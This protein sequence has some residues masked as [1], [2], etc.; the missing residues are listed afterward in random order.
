MDDEWAK[1]QAAERR[2]H[3]ELDK[4]SRVAEESAARF[5]GRDD[6]AQ[7]CSSEFL[8]SKL[9][10]WCL[11][12]YAGEL[13]SEAELHAEADAFARRYA[14]R[15]RTRRK[16]EP[17]LS[18]IPAAEVMR[19]PEPGPEEVV[20]RAELLAALLRPL[21]RLAP[22]QQSLFVRR[23]LE[24]ERLVDLEVETGRTANAL[25]HA[26][27]SVLHRLRSL[28]EGEAF[29]TGEIEDYLSILDAFQT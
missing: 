15:R 4:L 6:Y 10:A 26:V 18:E 12:G 27:A 21:P 17:L 2:L 8:A 3:A 1:R 9:T 25:G 13:G 16:R 23:M 11:S 5:V 20:V 7:D 19:S 22:R 28:L 14:F 29:G 24:E